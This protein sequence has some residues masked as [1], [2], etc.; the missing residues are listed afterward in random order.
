VI[1]QD[2]LKNWKTINW[3]KLLNSGKKNLADVSGV[4]HAGISV[5]WKFAGTG[6]LLRLSPRTGNPKKSIL[7]KANFFNL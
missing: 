5:R 6:V 4:M 7:K 1:E 3:K 2:Y